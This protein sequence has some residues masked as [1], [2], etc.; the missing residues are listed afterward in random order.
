MD[1]RAGSKTSLLVFDLFLRNF[2][3]DNSEFFFFAERR[4]TVFG[5]FGMFSFSFYVR[6]FWPC[7]SKKKCYKI[8]GSWKNTFIRPSPINL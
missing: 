1:S 6:F 2:V 3:S 5:F 4:E 8:S 7:T